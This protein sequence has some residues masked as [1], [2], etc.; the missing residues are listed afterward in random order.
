[1]PVEGK[2]QHGSIVV[3]GEDVDD[4]VNHTAENEG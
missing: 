1:M 2:E 3:V 4:G